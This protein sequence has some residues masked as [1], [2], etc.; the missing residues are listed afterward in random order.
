M[1]DVL[2]TVDRPIF[3]AVLVTVTD[4]FGMTAPLGSFTS[5][6]ISP[7][8]CAV[9]TPIAAHKSA[10]IRNNLFMTPL[11]QT[12]SEVASKLS[13]KDVIRK[14]STYPGEHVPSTFRKK[15]KRPG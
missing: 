8:V 10:A 6:V 15:R 1:P 5:P 3:V 11:K 9:A 13:Q 7:D 12:W 2:V 14:G 4:A